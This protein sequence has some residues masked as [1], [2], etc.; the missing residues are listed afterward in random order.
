MVV[1]VTAPDGAVTELR[2]PVVPDLDAARTVADLRPA[3]VA[4]D[5][6]PVGPT[7]V[8]ATLVSPLGD[9]I[10]ARSQTPPHLFDA[11]G[12]D[13]GAGRVAASS[14]W[15][16][17]I[18]DGHTDD[19]PFTLR[20]GSEA[21]AAELARRAAPSREALAAE[22]SA[23]TS[24][25]D[26]ME[27]TLEADG[28]ASTG[29]VLRL[30]D[31]QGRV[32]ALPGV[33][34]EVE[35]GALD[36]AASYAMDGSVVRRVVVGA[37]PGTL[38]ARV[39]VRDDLTLA[40]TIALVAPRAEAVTSLEL[41][42]S[43]SILGGDAVALYATAFPARRQRAPGGGQPRRHARPRRRPD[44]GDRRPRGVHDPLAQPRPGQTAAPAGHRPGQSGARARGRRA[45]GGAGASARRARR[46]GRVAGRAA[47]RDRAG[48]GRP[49][50]RGRARR[51]RIDRGPA[52][53]GA[54]VP[55]GDEPR[56][57]RPTMDGS[58]GPRFAKVTAA[59]ASFMR[60]PLGRLPE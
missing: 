45:R 32:I 53:A 14:S 15:S 24:R 18:D 31:G 8:L 9:P 41:C 20:V 16:F 2:V 1:R 52:P 6:R 37:R 47:L 34:W 49:V 10:S 30:A 25:L 50:R 27:A 57:A 51:R 13:L 3:V 35:G 48:S 59:R 36:E 23:A 19:G 22:V 46:P 29:L 38:S 33:R 17:A 40:T 44:R 5:E 58:R 54:R 21:V 39:R 55:G 26:P 12:N 11:R 42:V 28:V 43:G 56:L 4:A 60:Q 7:S